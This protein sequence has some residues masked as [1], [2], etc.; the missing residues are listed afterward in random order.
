M[1][2]LDMTFD[3][4]SY[5]LTAALGEDVPAGPFPSTDALDGTAH[6][7]HLALVFLPTNARITTQVTALNATVSVA[8]SVAPRAAIKAAFEFYK[9][10][11][12][13]AGDSADEVYLSML[14][15]G[16][17]TFEPWTL[18]DVTP[19]TS[20]TDYFESAVTAI[21]VLASKGTDGDVRPLNAYVHLLS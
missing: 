10:T 5:R 6:P 14:G 17:T 2:I 13:A 12:L 20:A 3:G 11:A 15:L 19:D 9:A 8:Y 16:K 4:A 7:G 18:G 1:Q 21:L